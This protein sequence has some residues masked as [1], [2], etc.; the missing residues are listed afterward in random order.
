MKPTEESTPP[1]APTAALRPIELVLQNLAPFA[2]REGASVV[3]PF[4][5]GEVMDLPARHVPN[6]PTAWQPFGA[7][8]PD[9]SVRQ[10][11]CLFATEIGPLAEVRLALADGA[12]PPLPTG[13]VAMPEAR[14]EFVV[15]QG[16]TTTRAE[17]QRVE[18]LESNALRRV[19]LRRTRIGTTGLIAELIVTAW[20]DQPHAAIDA[21]VFFSDPSTPA[22]SCSVDELAIE[23]RGMAIVFRHPGWLGIEQTTTDQGSRNVMLKQNTFGDGQGLRRTGALVP[24][25][26]SDGSLADSTSVAA[27]IAPL[28]GATPW[29]QSGAFGA[30]GYVPELPPWLRGSALR[31]HLALRHRVFVSNDQPGG[32]P[33]GVFAHGLARMAGQ[34]GDQN[35]FG[36]V[37]MTLVAATGLPSFLLEVELSMLQ[38]ACR[39]VHFF[40]IDASPVDPEKHP[41]WNVWAGRTHWHAGQSSDRLGKG[42]PQ[43]PFDNHGWTGK[44]R[45][46]W[47]NNYLGAFALLSGS[48]WARQELANEVRLYLAGQTTDPKLATSGSD[49]PRGGGRTELSA[50]WMLLATGDAKLQQRMNERMD[51]V[52]HPQWSGRD[53][54]ADRVRTMSVCTPDPRMLQGSCDYWN[55]WQDS[56]AAVGFG[57]SY[58]LTGNPLARELAEELALNVVRCGWLLNDRECYIATAM[59]WQDGQPLSEEQRAA[60]DPTVVAWSFGTAYSEWSIGALEI[61]RVAALARGD[62]ALAERAAT[63]QARMRSGRRPPPQDSSQFG[64]IDRMAEWDAVRW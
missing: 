20:R 63:I 26:H 23:C 6:T 28:L 64:G 1:A 3:V 52:Y 29:Q 32:D 34:T 56:L 54:A 62:Q 36:T 7:R 50:S 15:V 2:R 58:K 19:E 44:D 39:P 5:A 51:R 38:E 37:K 24:P 49:A 45:Q 42:E 22:M 46:H 47:S 21:A 11:L 16:Q 17:P 8:W 48:H 10:A 43:P 40:E 12:G 13:A 53:L 30:F 35:D 25:L 4:A 31:A 57:A 27:C 18:D 59:R 60:R 41:T 33:F 55:P 61:A 14:I 9:G